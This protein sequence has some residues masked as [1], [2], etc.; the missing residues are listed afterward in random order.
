MSAAEV[1][2]APVGP[3]DFPAGF[4]ETAGFTYL[5]LKDELAQRRDPA[6][7]A[8]AR[9]R[10]QQLLLD[11]D[12]GEIF[13]AGLHHYGEFFASLEYGWDLIH[14]RVALDGRPGSVVVVARYANAVQLKWRPDKEAPALREVVA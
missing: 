4:A 10:F 5:D 12:Y 13:D 7:V 6:Y 14:R 1:F 8:A 3:D 2:A 11:L 9:P